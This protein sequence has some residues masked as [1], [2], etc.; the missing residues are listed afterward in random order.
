MLSRDWKC[1]NRACGRIFHSFEK[2]NPPCSHCGCVKV[3][4]VPGGGHIA[5]TSPGIDQTVRQLAH[6]YG[7]SDINTPSKSRLNRAMPKFAQRVP[8]LPVQHFAPGFSAPVSSQGATCQESTVT[9]NAV[10]G[11][12][13]INRAL[14]ASGM[15]PNP[16]TN[17]RIVARNGG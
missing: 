1:L 13:V 12:V 15:F 9:G 2:G 5:K 6:D 16:M 3:A 8:D 4:W 7:M 10:F 14:P 17:T 11:K